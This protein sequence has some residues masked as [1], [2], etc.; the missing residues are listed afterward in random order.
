M[1]G[2]RVKIAEL[3]EGQLAKLRALES[4]LGT[5]VVALEREFRLAELSDEKLGKLQGV[6][7]ELG[8]VLL[9]Y[10]AEQC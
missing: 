2:A 1:S 7:D 6:E 5:W 9:A 8:V 3:D 4:E 10:E